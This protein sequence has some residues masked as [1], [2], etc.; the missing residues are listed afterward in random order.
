MKAD[1]LTKLECSVNQRRLL[2]HHNCDYVF[3]EEVDDDDEELQVE[4]SLA[5]VFLGVC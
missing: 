5:C 1:G 3:P 2:L 4:A